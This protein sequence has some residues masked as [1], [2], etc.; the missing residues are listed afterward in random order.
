MSMVS[1]ESC[2]SLCYFLFQTKMVFLLWKFSNG[3]EPASLRESLELSA[4]RL[5]KSPGGHVVSQ[6]PLA[7]SCSSHRPCLHHSGCAWLSP[8]VSVQNLSIAHQSFSSFHGKDCR[9]LQWWWCKNQHLWH[10][11]QNIPILGF[12]LIFFSHWQ[13]WKFCCCSCPAVP[14]TCKNHIVFVEIFWETSEHLYWTDHFLDLEIN[15]SYE[16]T[17]FLHGSCNL[18]LAMFFPSVETG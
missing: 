6:R 15:V 11:L 7:K 1:L 14:V 8:L 10:S 16:M 9:L 3:W 5:R 17:L 12:I 2:A 18:H 4:A 13:N